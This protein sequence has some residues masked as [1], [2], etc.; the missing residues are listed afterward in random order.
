[1]NK[2]LMN[3]FFINFEVIILNFQLLISFCKQLLSKFYFQMLMYK[4]LTLQVDVLHLLP[5]YLDLQLYMK[6]IFPGDWILPWP[7]FMHT[8]DQICDMLEVVWNTIWPSPS[9]R[10]TTFLSL[11]VWT[12]NSE[13]RMNVSLFMPISLK[14]VVIVD[15]R[16]FALSQFNSKI[17]FL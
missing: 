3:F 7:T 8:L 16:P 5:A 17:M 1:M 11:F 10:W 12:L 13:Q 9:R 2:I 14:Y 6:G 4:F 15:N